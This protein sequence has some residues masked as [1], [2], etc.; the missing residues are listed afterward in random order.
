MISIRSRSKCFAFMMAANALIFSTSLAQ[1]PTRSEPRVVLQGYDS[2]S[3]F[4][5][6]KAVKGTPTISYDWDEGRYQFSSAKNRQAFSEN[7]DRFAPQFGGFCTAGMAKGVKAEANPEFFTVVNGKLYTFSSLK[8]RDAALA[9]PDL[10]AQAEK[11]W[12]DKR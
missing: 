7:P 1:T 10:F 12:K 9:D 8:A 4:S 3:Y 11:N 2:V 5:D 6:N